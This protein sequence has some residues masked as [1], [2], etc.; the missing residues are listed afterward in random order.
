MDRDDTVILSRVSYIAAY[1]FL[2]ESDM[3]KK[4]VEFTENSMEVYY[5]EYLSGENG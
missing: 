3:I 5:A 1:T 4:S 2:K